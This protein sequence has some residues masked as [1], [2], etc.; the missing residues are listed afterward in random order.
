[1]SK[2]VYARLDDNTIELL[3]TECE[4]RNVYRP[5]IVTEAVL[6][7]FKYSG[8]LKAECDDLKGQLADAKT[9]LSRQTEL[10]ET[11]TKVISEQSSRAEA[12]ETKVSQLET[13]NKKLDAARNS[14]ISQ[15]N[16]FKQKFE[17]ALQTNEKLIAKIRE[18]QGVGM[19]KRASR[20]KH[21]VLTRFS[22]PTEDSG[23]E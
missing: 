22:I 20:L 5:E 1:M 17:Q 16:K 15:R 4:K 21:L 10:N 12:A 6:R 19:F 8:D 9:E 11:H 3:D 18:L 7:H 2:Q 14:T 13:Q 23:K